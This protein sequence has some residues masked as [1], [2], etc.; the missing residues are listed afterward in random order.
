MHTYMNYEALLQEKAR[1][2]WGEKAIA[3]F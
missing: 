1:K 2:N 3:Q